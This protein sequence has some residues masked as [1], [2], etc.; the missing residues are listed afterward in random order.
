MRPT[1]AR[2]CDWP[3]P[4]VM[5]P[6]PCGK[7]PVLTFLRDCWAARRLRLVDSNSGVRCPSRQVVEGID[8]EWLRALVPEVV[9][10]RG[11]L[12]EA[13]AG[14]VL[15]G[16][17][18][19][20]AVVERSFTLGD[21]DERRAGM[22]V[23][24]G[25]SARGN[26][27]LLERDI[28]G[29]RGTQD[30]R[31][32]TVGDLKADALSERLLSDT[33][34]HRPRDRGRLRNTNDGLV[35]ERSA[36]DNRT[37][38]DR[39]T[40]RRQSPPEP[41]ATATVTRAPRTTPSMTNRC[42]RAPAEPAR[43]SELLVLSSCSEGSFISVLLLV[44]LRRLGPQRVTQH[45][46]TWLMGGGL[47]LRHSGWS[48]PDWF[49]FALRAMSVARRCPGVIARKRLDGEVLQIRRAALGFSPARPRR[50]LDRR[51]RSAR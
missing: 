26:R 5:R 37:T 44:E 23:P 27:Q 4:R 10:F 14:G 34:L 36:C 32:W 11:R 25:V 41:S 22:G 43:T 45:G 50:S 46:V 17:T 9:N 8:N 16:G 1:A 47:A 12:E 19:R 40:R 42:L 48:L 30:I 3:G 39:G 7:Q 31:R 49:R 35:R 18:S 24:P 15:V 6:R 33:Y 29:G 13:G 20:D 51:A 28:A 21:R 38:D 2:R